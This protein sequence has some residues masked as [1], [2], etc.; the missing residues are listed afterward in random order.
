MGCSNCT[1]CCRSWMLTAK[2]PDG[3]Q[4][5]VE[6]HYGRKLERVS[7]SVKHECSKLKDGLCT[8]YDERPELCKKFE[9]RSVG[10]TLVLDGKE[11]GE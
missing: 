8:I 1:E 11:K 7:I 5:L 6:A 4:G 10:D 9:C 3:L 2:I